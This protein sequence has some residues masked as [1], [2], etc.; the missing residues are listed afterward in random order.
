M[1]NA[2][3]DLDFLRIDPDAFSLCPEDSIDYVVMEKTK[4]ALVVPMMPAGMILVLGLR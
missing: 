1:T 4:D 2:S 3:P